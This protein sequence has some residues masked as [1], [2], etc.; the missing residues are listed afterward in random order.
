M[1]A[2]PTSPLRTAYRRGRAFEHRVL[3][4]LEAAG[5]LVVRSAGSKGAADLVAVKAGLV[6]LVQARKD[7]CLPPK[8]WNRLLEQAGLAGAVAVLVEQPAVRGAEVRWWRLLSPKDGTGGKQP[9]EAL[10]I[11]VQTTGDAER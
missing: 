3:A 9:R 11:T 6:L 7:G 1:T 10:T 4:D 5:F 8:E 2:P